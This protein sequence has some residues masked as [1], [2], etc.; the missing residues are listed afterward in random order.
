M[1]HVKQM[2]FGRACF[3]SGVNKDDLQILSD[4]SIEAMGWLTIWESK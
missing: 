3:E 2:V 1:I 4:A